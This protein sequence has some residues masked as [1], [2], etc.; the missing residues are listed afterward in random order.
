MSAPLVITAVVASGAVAIGALAA[1]LGSG[2]APDVD[3][4]QWPV[5]AMLCA[6][7]FFL[8]WRMEKHLDRKDA[9]ALDSQEKVA[10]EVSSAVQSSAQ[11]QKEI[12]E[13]QRDSTRQ[14][15]QAIQDG[16]RMLAD[17]IGRVGARVAVLVSQNLSGGDVTADDVERIIRDACS[18]HRG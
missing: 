5:A 15:T 7:I 17:K 14:L 1:S 8:L 3:W 11:A 16:D 4:T 9:R 12:A 2:A 18:E 13:A 10:G 6:V